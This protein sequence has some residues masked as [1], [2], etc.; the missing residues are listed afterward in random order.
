MRGVTLSIMKS[1]HVDRTQNV[2]VGNIFFT[3]KKITT[4]VPQG[5]HLSPLLFLIHIYNVLGLF[6]GLEKRG[7][8]QLRNALISA[9]MHRLE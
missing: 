4:G 8:K 9:E 5:F 2:S 6:Y 7:S 1:Y 3:K